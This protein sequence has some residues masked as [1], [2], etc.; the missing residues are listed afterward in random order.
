MEKIDSK[1]GSCR[2][3]SGKARLTVS[4]GMIIL[5]IGLMVLPGC[6]RSGLRATGI[7]AQA[8]IVLPGAYRV[9]GE[10]EGTSSSFTLLWVFPVTPRVNYEAAVNDAITRLGGDNLINVRTWIERQFWVAGTVEIVRVR[11][12]VIAYGEELDDTDK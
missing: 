4:T 12:T 9:L 5:A 7:E 1:K 3:K 11:G 10:A 2:V 6:L 8:K